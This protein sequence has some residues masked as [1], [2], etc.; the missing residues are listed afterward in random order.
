[1]LARNIAAV[2]GFHWWRGDKLEWL[3]NDY[4]L[5]YGGIDS[6]A[7]TTRLGTPNGIMINVAARMSAEVS[8]AGVAYDF[9]K[10]RDA[11]ALFPYVD[12][13][14]RPLDDN[15]YE[16]PEAISRIRH[17]I[18]YLHQRI[19]GET[20]S[21][22][23]PELD[24][25]YQLFLETWRELHGIGDGSLQWDCQGRWDRTTFKDLPMDQIIDNDRNFTIRSWMAVVTYL[26]SDYKF[27]Y[28]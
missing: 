19:L 20:L 4:N 23:D 26:L 21:D 16:I 6:D 25:T 13:S 17:N 3:T 27:L 28:E 9:T 5:L 15:G 11:R 10:A 14:Y 8:C 12:P 2:M 22:S 1:M 24:R 18:Q 7:V